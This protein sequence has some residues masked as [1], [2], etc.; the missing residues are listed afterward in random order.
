MADPL[1]RWTG[2]TRVGR[3][4]AVGCKPYVQFVIAGVGPAVA[5]MA[6]RPD[7]PCLV[8]LVPPDEDRPLL[9]LQLHHS[10]ARGPET[11]LVGLVAE[12]LVMAVE[13]VGL[14]VE[15]SEAGTRS[16]VPPQLDVHTLETVRDQLLFVPRLSHMGGLPASDPPIH[17]HDLW[18]EY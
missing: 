2:P 4:L 9:A 11:V 17:D 1:Y 18:L 15:V 14:A 6:L 12:V 10:R 3:R 7:R 13:V 8:A 5:R 16:V